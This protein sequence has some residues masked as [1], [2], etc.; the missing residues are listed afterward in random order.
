MG[1]MRLRLQ[2][3]SNAAP[4]RLLAAAAT[5][6]DD[7]DGRRRRRRWRRTRG[8]ARFRAYVRVRLPWLIQK[9]T[10]SFGKTTRFS[11]AQILAVP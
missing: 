7:D 8:H 9:T 5:K 6:A 10:I 4:L 11:Y 1:K 2:I 3:V